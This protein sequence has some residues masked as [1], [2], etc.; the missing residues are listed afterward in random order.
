MLKRVVFKSA[1]CLSAF[2]A[3]LGWGAM[4]EAEISEP[5]PRSVQCSAAFELMQRAAPEWS[6]QY[7]VQSAREFWRTDL[8]TLV[9]RAGLDAETQIASEMVDMA[10][11]SIA[12]PGVITDTAM[13]CVGDADLPKRRKILGLF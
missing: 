5:A 11:A 1:F 2:T 10:E 9:A 6:G 7:V 3:G 4:A 8:G 12:N 13:Q